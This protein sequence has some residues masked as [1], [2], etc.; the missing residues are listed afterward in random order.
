[1]RDFKHPII[2]DNRNLRENIPSIQEHFN[3][4]E[5]EIINFP[6]TDGLVKDPKIVTFRDCPIC[7]SKKYSAFY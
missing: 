7:T 5:K 3:S 1:M 2:K 4:I 6:K